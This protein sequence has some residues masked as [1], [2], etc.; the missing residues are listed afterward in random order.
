MHTCTLYYTLLML[1]FKMI[2][3][4]DSYLAFQRFKCWVHY[5]SNTVLKKLSTAPGELMT[6]LTTSC[7]FTSLSWYFWAKVAFLTQV[8]VEGGWDRALGHCAA[9]GAQFWSFTSIFPSIS[10]CPS[11]ASGD[12]RCLG[13]ICHFES[14]ALG[15]FQL[16]FCSGG[17]AC[18][19]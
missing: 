6:L 1:L 16:S 13:H 10:Q 2:F 14:S 5:N 4:G 18:I 8:S 7:Q 9:G 17:K 15:S 11:E 19:F 12:R 3:E